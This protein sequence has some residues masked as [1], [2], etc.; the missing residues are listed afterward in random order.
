MSCLTC[1]SLENS[2]LE[3]D[4]KNNLQRAQKLRFYVSVNKFLV[5]SRQGHQF[6]GLDQYYEKLMRHAQEHISGPVKFE[7]K[8]SQT[9][10]AAQPRSIQRIE[11][12][13]HYYMG[14]VLIEIENHRKKFI[15]LS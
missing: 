7:T 3:S 10:F 9:E 11:V 1:H 5:T 14:F 12:V 6:L 4:R 13:C 15:G 2:Q 8:S